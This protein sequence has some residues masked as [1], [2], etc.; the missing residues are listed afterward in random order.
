MQNKIKLNR[1]TIEILLNQFFMPD[2]QQRNE[3]IINEY[4]KE[5]D[6]TVT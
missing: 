6:V 2:N 3:E 1:K 5:N 4:S